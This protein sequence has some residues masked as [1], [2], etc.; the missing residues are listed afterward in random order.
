MLQDWSCCEGLLEAP[1]SCN[2]RVRAGELHQFSCECSEGGGQSR[3][4]ANEFLVEVGESN[5]A[6]LKNSGIALVKT[7]KHT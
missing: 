3:V 6:L 5:T 1:E 4:V 7:L 2:R